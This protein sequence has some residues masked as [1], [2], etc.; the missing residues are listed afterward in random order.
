[1]WEEG[2]YPNSTNPPSPHVA[3]H[4]CE[5]FVNIPCKCDNIQ[6]R[7]KTKLKI[8]YYFDDFNQCQA[9]WRDLIRW[10]MR[11]ISENIQSEKIFDETA[12]LKPD[13]RP[14]ISLIRQGGNIQAISESTSIYLFNLKYGK[15]KSL[16]FVT[17]VRVFPDC[18]EEHGRGRP[19]AHLL[20]SSI[21][22]AVCCYDA[23]IPYVV[24]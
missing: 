15:I 2:N 10:C 24:I 14:V 16:S 7:W 8:K 6:Q 13:A 4:S 20:P 21:L 17:T 5:G 22:S 11:L 23:E 19:Q 18:P 12:R 3:A 1:M 9:K